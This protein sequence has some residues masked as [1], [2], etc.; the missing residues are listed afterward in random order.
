M[1]GLPGGKNRQAL[2]LVVFKN[3]SLGGWG[4]ER[5]GN[6]K[7][8]EWNSLNNDVVRWP[9]RAIA[10]SKVQVSEGFWHRCILGCSFIG[11]GECVGGPHDQHEEKEDSHDCFRNGTAQRRKFLRIIKETSVCTTEIAESIRDHLTIWKI[12]NVFEV[13]CRDAPRLSPDGLAMM[14]AKQLGYSIDFFLY[15]S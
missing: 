4:D 12:L 5:L 15:R 10:K 13:F 11:I 6:G 7:D 8:G 9:E 2:P 1:S 14:P 3:D